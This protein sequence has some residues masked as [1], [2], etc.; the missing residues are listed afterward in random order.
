MMSKKI[1]LQVL[2]ILATRDGF[3]HGKVGPIMI[4]VPVLFPN[5]L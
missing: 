3:F 2:K 4:F 5:G 1:L